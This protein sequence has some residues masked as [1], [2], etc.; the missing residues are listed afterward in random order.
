MLAVI[1][2]SCNGTCGTTYFSTALNFIGLF[3]TSILSFVIHSTKE[4]NRSNRISPCPPER[5]PFERHDGIG[6]LGMIWAGE[7]EVK[8]RAHPPPPPPAPRYT[9]DL[10]VLTASGTLTHTL[11]L[12]HTHMNTQCSLSHTCAIQG[13]KG[14]K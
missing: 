12:T 9:H 5:Q 13:D 4:A 2:F 10:P 7:V 3:K 14:Q 6:G 11:S 1:V 8:R